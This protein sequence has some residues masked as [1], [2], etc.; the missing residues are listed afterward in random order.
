M[1]KEKREKGRQEVEYA[2]GEAHLQARSDYYTKK[3]RKRRRR[4]FAVSNWLARI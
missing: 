1:E 3:A 4:F 2:R